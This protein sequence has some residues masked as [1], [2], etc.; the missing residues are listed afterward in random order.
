[1]R[2]REIDAPETAN[3]QLSPDIPPMRAIMDRVR[4][5]HAGQIWPEIAVQF[6]DDRGDLT[7]VI[8]CPGL[9]VHDL[10]ESFA[11]EYQ[12]RRLW[13]RKNCRH[14]FSVE[15]IR[16]AG[17]RDTGRRFRFADRTD[18]ARFRRHWG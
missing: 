5:F 12:G 17:Q 1:M 18:A 2:Y 4:A 6:A 7:H 16:E 10:G 13:C 8:E 15:P 3:P 11:E 9:T 14:K